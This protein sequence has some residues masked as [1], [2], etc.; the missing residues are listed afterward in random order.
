MKNLKNEVQIPTIVFRGPDQEIEGIIRDWLDPYYEQQREDAI[1]NFALILTKLGMS[2]EE[3]CILENAKGPSSFDC[4]SMNIKTKSIKNVKMILLPETEE[5]SKEIQI[6]KNGEIYTFS[7]WE[8]Y[9]DKDETRVIN[10][11]MS[12]NLRQ[13]KTEG[14][15]Q[16]STLCHE[17]DAFSYQLTIEDRENRIH[18]FVQYPHF[19]TGK[20]NRYININSPI[21]LT[22]FPISLAE[23]EKRFEIS[24]ALSKEEYPMIKIEQYKK[25]DGKEILQSQLLREY[26]KVK[27]L[28][29]KGH[30]DNSLISVDNQGI[31]QMHDECGSFRFDSQKLLKEEKEKNM[32]D[33]MI[34][35]RIQMA[36]ALVQKELS[37]LNACEKTFDFLALHDFV[38]QKISLDQKPENSE[39][40]FRRI[41]KRYEEFNDNNEKENG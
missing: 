3:T 29:L 41:L 5:R 36:I 11:P 8:G 22:Q 37:E 27:Q 17:F 19:L 24:L 33:Q 4:C 7:Y 13:I 12:L 2:A 9:Y 18:I 1:Q 28:K 32:L 6:E 20:E 21:E 26:G 38:E 39:P 35:F 34:E 30:T 23:I 10:C 14:L 31:I 40:L 15:T 16:D 25:R